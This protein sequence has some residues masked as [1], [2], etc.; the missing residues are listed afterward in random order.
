MG[1]LAEKLWGI[2][3]DVSAEIGRSVQLSKVMPKDVL[4][5][6]MQVTGLENV[7]KVG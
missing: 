4:V 7:S 6:I 5:V 1:C 2:G 3:I